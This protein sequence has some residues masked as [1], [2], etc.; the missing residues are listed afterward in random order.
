MIYHYDSPI[1]LLTIS[2][3]GALRGLWTSQ[4]VPADA[5]TAVAAKSS[6]SAEPGSAAEPGSTAEPVTAWLDAYFAGRNPTIDFR[7]EQTGTPF[8]QATWQ[9]LH[10]IPYGHTVSYGQLAVVVGKKLGRPTSARAIGAAVGRNQ[11]L[12]AV[13]CHRVIGANG[14]MTGYAGGLDSKRRLLALE[15]SE[16]PDT[17]QES[18]ADQA[19]I[20]TGSRYIQ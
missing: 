10:A 2:Y 20:A 17:D 7:I 9:A 5:A 6:C 8:Q 15:R 19:H 1:G 18:E 3:D 14:S 4:N 13:P 11:V 16:C 12:I